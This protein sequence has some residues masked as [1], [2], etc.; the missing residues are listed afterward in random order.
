MGHTYNYIRK[1]YFN[2]QEIVGVEEMTDFTG[3]I[4]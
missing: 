1:E 2:S 3:H 4:E